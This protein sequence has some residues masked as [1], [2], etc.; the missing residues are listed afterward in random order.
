MVKSTLHHIAMALH[1][2]LATAPLPG[3]V[4]ALPVADGFTRIIADH[5]TGTYAG[6]AISPFSGGL[7]PILLHYDH[8]RSITDS[9]DGSPVGNLSLRP[10]VNGAGAGL[11]CDL[12]F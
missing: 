4:S 7:L 5:A 3:P 2:T 6:P 1:L 11:S 12:R 8:L 9:T 10:Q